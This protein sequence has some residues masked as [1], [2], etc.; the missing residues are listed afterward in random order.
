MLKIDSET[1][2]FTLLCRSGRYTQGVIQNRIEAIAIEFTYGNT[3]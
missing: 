1:E 3:K 2:E